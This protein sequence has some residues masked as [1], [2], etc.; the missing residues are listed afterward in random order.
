MAGLVPLSF[1]EREL[2]S[3]E[4]ACGKSARVIAGL[5]GRHHSIVARE[6]KNNGG[7]ERYRAVVADGRGRGST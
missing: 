5:L 4:I 2:I 7:R 3:R 1:E 6:I